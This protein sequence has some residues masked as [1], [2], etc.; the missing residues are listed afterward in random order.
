MLKEMIRK[1]VM[2]PDFMAR[3]QNGQLQLAGISALEQRALM[4]VMQDRKPDE[5]LRKTVY[6]C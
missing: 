6:W 1:M 5:S 4:D 3:I 2:E